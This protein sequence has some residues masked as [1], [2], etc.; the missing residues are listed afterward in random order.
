MAFQGKHDE[1]EPL[2]VRSLAIKEK[3]YGPDHPEVATGLNS[4]AGLLEEQVGAIGGFEIQSILV[5]C[6]LVCEWLLHGEATQSAVTGCVSKSRPS[7]RRT[8]MRVF[9]GSTFNW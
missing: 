2:C 8:K 1:A 6:T 5:G 3:V 4:M 7:V 9:L